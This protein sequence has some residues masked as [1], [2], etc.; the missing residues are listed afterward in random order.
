M[1]VHPLAANLFVLYFGIISDVTP[2]VCL[3]AF[4]A[5]AIAKS[6]ALKTGVQASKNAV[7]GFLTP[8]IFVLSPSLL[9]IDFQP[10]EL[11]FHTI[12]AIIGMIAISSAL[13]GY[14][15][16]PMKLPE[17]GLLVLGGIGV[18]IPN[19]VSS[20]IGLGVIA[21][22]WGGQVSRK[23]RGLTASQVP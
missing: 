7:G 23:K 1:G 6:D 12:T 14:L 8:F 20:I 2:P 5:S 17:R 22:V 21:A 9:L 16:L 13:T 4:A 18:V 11:L 3:S 19:I 15:L 10:F